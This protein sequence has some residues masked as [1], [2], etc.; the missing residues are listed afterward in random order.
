MTF[1]RIDSTQANTLRG[2][3]GAYHALDPVPL[4]DTDNYILTD[5]VLTEPAFAPALATLEALP[6]YPAWQSGAS[7][8]A[9]DVV[10]YDERLWLIVQPHTSQADW[11]PDATPA[12]W[13]TS[14]EPGTIPAW[15]APTGAHDAYQLGDRVTHNGSVWESTVDANVWEPGTPGTESLWSV[16]P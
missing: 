11:T 4:P 12:L 3:Y 9:D 2:S 10:E 15:V 7:Y 5:A 13:R 8:V 16:V 14:H 6:V 1:M